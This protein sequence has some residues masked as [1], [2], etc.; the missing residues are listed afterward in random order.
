MPKYIPDSSDKEHSI[1]LPKISDYISDRAQQ[2]ELA[3]AGEF[4]PASEYPMRFLWGTNKHWGIVTPNDV[5][6]LIPHEDEKRVFFS[7]CM[8]F[9]KARGKMLEE[10]KNLDSFFNAN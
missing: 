10:L 5:V 8:A 9:Y 4:N 3:A 2:I 1:S 7:A 6:W